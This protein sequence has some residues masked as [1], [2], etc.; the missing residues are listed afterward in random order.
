MVASDAALFVFVHCPLNILPVKADDGGGNS[1]GE[2][3]V[4]PA[5]LSHAGVVRSTEVCDRKTLI[6]I[7][8]R[9]FIKDPCPQSIAIS[10]LEPAV[11]PHL[12]VSLY[13]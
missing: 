5:V 6:R 11:S 1:A 7:S 10:N 2:L 9:S 13:S 4:W 3:R 12:N 8:P